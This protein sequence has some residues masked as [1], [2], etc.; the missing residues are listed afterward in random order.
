MKIRLV[1]ALVGFAIGFVL[2][3]F[4][5]DQ[6]AVDPEVRQQIEDTIRKRLDALSKL[7]AAA[8]AALYTQDAVLVNA[9]GAGDVLT[10]GQEAIKKTFDV[11][12]AAG[13][14]VSDPRILQMYQVGSEVCTIGEFTFERHQKLHTVTIYVREADEWKIR[15]QYVTR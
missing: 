8:V 7:D 14:P 10:S 1:V 11:I 15:M 4:A 5:Q 3:T 6:N 13:S 2:P 12:L 9:A